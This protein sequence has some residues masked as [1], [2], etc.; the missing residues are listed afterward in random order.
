M[1][2]LI[3][4]R[5]F[6]VADLVRVSCQFSVCLNLLGFHSPMQEF[7]I[8]ASHF[9]VLSC[10]PFLIWIISPVMQH[11]ELLLTVTS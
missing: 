10:G 11:E 9:A 2:D 6:A 7:V 4:F 3:E 8:I 5:Y 1:L